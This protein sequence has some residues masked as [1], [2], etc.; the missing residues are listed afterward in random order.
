M[1]KQETSLTANEQLMKLGLTCELQG[2]FWLMLDKDFN[3]KVDEESIHDIFELVF[4]ELTVEQL[5]NI[6][7]K[8][9]SKQAD[10][11][12]NLPC[13]KELF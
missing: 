4:N 2:R 10:T 13:V 3:R 6:L 12:K 5:I 9:D 1:T 8:I 7:S 11:I